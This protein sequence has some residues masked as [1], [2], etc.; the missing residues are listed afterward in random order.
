MD[1]VR[2]HV[3]ITFLE[4][5]PGFFVFQLCGFLPGFLGQEVIEEPGKQAAEFQTEVD[6][7]VLVVDA[8][9]QVGNIEGHRGRCFQ[10]VQM[11]FKH[12]L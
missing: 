6:I 3:G 5:F 9:G 1:H 7:N 12:R 10:L 2:H 4:F 8:T 11:V